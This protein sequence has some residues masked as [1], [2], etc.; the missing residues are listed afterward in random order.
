LGTGALNSN[1]GKTMSN[2]DS[3]T[4]SHLHA[5]HEKAIR[6]CEQRERDHKRRMIEDPAYRAEIEAKE[7]EE[8]RRRES[9]AERVL[10]RA[11]ETAGIEPRVIR[12]LREPRPTTALRHVR[13]FMADE[14]HTILL[15]AGSPG[16][17]KTVAACSAL[18]GA[19]RG[20]YSMQADH[21]GRFVKAI[22]LVRAG[23][24]DAAF[25]SGLRE[26]PVLVID[27]LGAEPLD[28]KGW[29]LANLASL[30]DSRYD[31]EAKTILTMNLTPARF[32][33]RYCAND[34]GR[35][36]DRIREVG[37]TVQIREPSMRRP[38]GSD[39]GQA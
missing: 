13:E 32:H 1:S 39:H 15:L 31:A 14:H 29:A 6:W 20:D 21:I 4:G 24:F 5:V 10:E 37:T 22:D 7:H 25:W 30:L 23:T 9:E 3:D 34:G 2:S 18:V 17:G 11:W 35:L 8:R 16:N 26:T 27:D 38:R 33:A 19:V 36:F 28:E 12:V